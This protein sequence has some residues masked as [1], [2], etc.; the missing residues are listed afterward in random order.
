MKSST[1]Y[2]IEVAPLVI[3]PLD[4]SP[5]F[6]YASQESIPKGSLVSI[7]FGSREIEGIVYNSQPL[8]GPQPRW[9][10]RISTIK[11][12][13][14]L[15]DGQRELGLFVSREYLTPLGKTLKH[16][17]PK[18]VK[19]R[20]VK[21][22]EELPLSSLRK[23]K[24]EEAVLKSFDK[25]P[26]G[27][28]GFLDTSLLPSAKH[29]LLLLAKRLATK[30]GQTLI[31]VPE[32]T[33]LAEWEREA[34]RYFPE[35][36]IALL[37]SQMANGPYFHAW[38]TVRSGEAKIILATR[39]G[40]FAPFQKLKLVAMTEEQDESYKQWDMSP[41]YHAKRI[42]KGLATFAKAA[43]IYATP[44]PSTDLA[45]SL[46]EQSVIPLLP[47][48]EGAPL[49]AILT[50]INLK[51]ERFRKNYSPLSE[52]LVATLRATLA[53]G[54]QS[55]L[56]IHRQGMSSFSLCESC[57]NIF[58]CPES[59]HPLTDTREG[60]YRCLGCPYK[61][62]L[63]PSCPVCGGLQ[64]RHVGFGTERIEK[65]VIK[66]FPGAKVFRADSS[67]MRKAGMLEKL[68]QKAA[69][70]EIDILIGTQMILK[71]PPLPSLGLI[72]MI[73]A[74]T[75]LSWPDFQADERF[76]QYL[77][78]AVLRVR[79]EGD[80]LGRVLVQTFQTESAFFQRANARNEKAFY[81]HMLEEREALFYPPFSRFIAL[82]CQHKSEEELRKNIQAL[83]ET[84]E[85]IAQSEPGLKLGLPEEPRI[86]KRQHLF[87]SSLL[88]RL[89][90]HESL[91]PQ[92]LAALTHSAKACTVDIDPLSF[93]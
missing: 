36:N 73:D 4:R 9:M 6:T 20:P 22:E 5:L 21:K 7:P 47:E 77:K 75:L 93:N 65:E 49:G 29:T 46:R 11:I 44:T 61:T 50:L 91:S 88:L 32:I 10:K 63:F 16:F 23:Q 84:L 52:E 53:A 38:E 26:V 31:L 41:R 89:P 33:L 87:E 1:L 42:A 40:L 15:T 59:G 13:A 43:L 74:D 80:G 71:S 81:E 85:K 62:P 72:A 86:L 18:P 17:T 34:R 27:T 79:R 66:L 64:F 69:S 76:Y 24:G 25:L 12:P 78:Q 67:T 45:L 2:R 57:K 68:S 82:S 35:E 39:Q 90:R 60:Y 51:L 37:H 70:G 56:Y 83:Y 54:K 58:R 19:M 30:G 8:P 55:L 48:E 3:L 92:L 14:Y 28:P